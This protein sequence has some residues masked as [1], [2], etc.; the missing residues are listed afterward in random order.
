MEIE[1]LERKFR[2]LMLKFDK[3]LNEVQNIANELKDLVYK[4]EKKEIKR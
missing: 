3:Q 2:I 4:N 1:E